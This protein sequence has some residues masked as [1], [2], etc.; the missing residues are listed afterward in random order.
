MTARDPERGK[1]ALEKVH[2]RGR[3]DADLV[4][5]DLPTCLGAPRAATSAPHRRPLHVLIQRRGHGL[6]FGLTP[7]FETQIA[8]TL[9]TPRR[10]A[11]HAACA[12]RRARW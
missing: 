11:A 12:P 9:G 3:P 8:P 6:A 7:T 10:P 5:L 1:A 4:E 2:E